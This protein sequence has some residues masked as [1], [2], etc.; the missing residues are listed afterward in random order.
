MVSE[1]AD[2]PKLFLVCGTEDFLYSNNQNFR[3]KLESLGV[4]HEYQEEPGTHEWGF[5]D[6]WIKYVVENLPIPNEE[7]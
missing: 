5:W 4:D 2:L 6:R 3:R 1:K 7:G